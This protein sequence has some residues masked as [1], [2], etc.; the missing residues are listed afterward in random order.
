[1]IKAHQA[2]QDE[3]YTIDL[4][5]G[6][7]AQFGAVGI[8]AY[9]KLEEAQQ[10]SSSVYAFPGNLKQLFSDAFNLKAIVQNFEAL[11]QYLAAAAYQAVLHQGIGEGEQGLEG[12]ARAYLLMALFFQLDANDWR[13]LKV[14]YDPRV[15]ITFD[16]MAYQGD[17]ITGTYVYGFLEPY[18]TSGEISTLVSRLEEASRRLVSQQQSLPFSRH[19]LVQ[20]IDQVD[21]RQ[22]RDALCQR[23]TGQ[24]HPTPIVV[25]VNGTVACHS[26]NISRDRAVLLCKQMGFAYCESEPIF[27][28][29]PG[30]PVPTSQVIP[31]PPDPSTQCTLRQICLY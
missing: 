14:F 8:F 5:T 7:I 17:G 25:I 12:V 1:M 16:F 31:E 13:W 6:I 26:Q 15:G 27:L 19:I 18:L 22:T 4:M 23:I 24:S 30:S 11:M 3:G 29:P 9:V 10:F 28:P 20:V 2:R 21:S